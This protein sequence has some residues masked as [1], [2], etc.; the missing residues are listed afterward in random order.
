MNNWQDIGSNI[1]LSPA[2]GAAVT[3]ITTTDVWI[4]FRLYV[5]NAVTGAGGIATINFGAVTR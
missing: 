1:L 3:N 4:H 5:D 2:G